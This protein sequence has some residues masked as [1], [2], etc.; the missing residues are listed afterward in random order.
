MLIPGILDLHPR[1]G[2]MPHNT[3]LCALLYTM[4]M[5]VPLCTC[6]YFSCAKV[7]NHNCCVCALLCSM[8]TLSSN[9]VWPPFIALY[10]MYTC[11][12]VVQCTYRW[13]ASYPSQVERLAG[14][15]HVYTHLATKMTNKGNLFYNIV[16]MYCTH[17]T[18][19]ITYMYMYPS[20]KGIYILH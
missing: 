5:Y 12:W 3:V 1:P 6:T 18:F 10:T 9:V 19:T 14:K 7:S 13:Q 15:E 8:V 2:K 17:I 20:H 16:S 4:Y 11:S